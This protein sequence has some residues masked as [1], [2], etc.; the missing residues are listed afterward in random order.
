MR[1]LHESSMSHELSSASWDTYCKVDRSGEHVCS[2]YK[3][4]FP[5]VVVVCEWK[6]EREKRD[7]SDTKWG[8][9]KDEER[10]L[11]VWSS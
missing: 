9:N 11:T 7:C 8:A 4:C 2:C 1:D 5:L 6:D 10:R 3:G